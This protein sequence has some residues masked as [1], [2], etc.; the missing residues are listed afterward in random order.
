MNRSDRLKKR[1]WTLYI[2]IAI[3]TLILF[4]GTW[5]QVAN[6]KNTF[7]PAGGTSNESDQMLIIEL[8]DGNVMTTEQKNIYYKGDKV[9]YKSKYNE[10]D[11]TGSKIK[12]KK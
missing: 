6:K 4:L 1:Q 5:N 11:I 2:A 3:F 9:Y 10:I 12:Q 7:V 8:P